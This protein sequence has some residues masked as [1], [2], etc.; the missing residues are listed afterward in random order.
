MINLPIRTCFH[1][2]QRN[3]NKCVRQKEAQP[4]GFHNP[5]ACLD[6]WCNFTKTTDIWQRANW[7]QKTPSRADIKWLWVDPG[8]QSSQF[9]MTPHPHPCAKPTHLWFLRNILSRHHRT[10]QCGQR[11]PVCSES[12][13]GRSCDYILN[14]PAVNSCDPVSISLCRPTVEDTA[15]LVQTLLV[16]CTRHTKTPCADATK[17]NREHETHL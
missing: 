6:I 10:H 15:D 12:V 9:F 3:K 13:P 7:N 17:G 16:L 5:W 4:N 2:S 14:L 11:Q 1:R 8:C